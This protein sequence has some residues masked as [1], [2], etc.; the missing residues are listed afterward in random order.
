MAENNRPN[1][2]QRNVTGQGTGGYRRGEGL[3][4]GPVGNQNG[5]SGRTGTGG[6]GGGQTTRASG[7]MGKIIG[8]FICRDIEPITPYGCLS[9]RY[10][11]PRTCKTNLT[12]KSGLYPES[13]LID[14]LLSILLYLVWHSINLPFLF[15]HIVYIFLVRK[16]SF[17]DIY[18][19]IVHIN[20]L[21]R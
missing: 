19:L 10:A 5:Y 7:G 8:E 4:T 18:I 2:R 15:D 11:T 1:G 16:S 6:G 12:I 17:L 9:I 3:G 20:I 21:I 13:K 14:Y